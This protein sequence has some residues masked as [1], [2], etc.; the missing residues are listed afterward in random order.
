M[1]A[2][3][4]LLLTLFATLASL[5]CL[6]AV[7]VSLVGTDLGSGSI[8]GRPPLSKQP[9]QPRIPACASCIARGCGC[10]TEKNEPRC[11]CVGDA[12]RGKQEFLGAGVTERIDA[13][14]GK[15]KR[16]MSER[17]AENAKL[18]AL[19]LQIVKK[20][21][22]EGLI[23]AKVEATQ[24][25]KDTTGETPASDTDLKTANSELSK[26]SSELTTAVDNITQVDVA[27][28]DARKST[29]LRRSTSSIPYAT[30]PSSASGSEGDAFAQS[31][32]L[33]ARQPGLIKPNPCDPAALRTALRLGTER[34]PALDRDQRIVADCLGR[35]P[36]GTVVDT[37]IAEISKP[38]VVDFH[39]LK[40][41]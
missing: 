38:P 18:Y 26:V 7:S 8:L 30:G 3:T 4:P 23:E 40:T 6:S 10:N 20:K 37:H 28:H 24:L 36:N 17:H 13:D 32:A 34:N 31:G 39:A 2:F 14:V 11:I 1:R 9:K 29:D 22:T 25:E 5:S 19:A 33:A 21:E 41:P 16:R 12:G 35:F 27:L 15:R